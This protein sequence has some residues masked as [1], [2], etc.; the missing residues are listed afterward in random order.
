ME[1][2]SSHRSITIFQSGWHL[3]V[4]IKLFIEECLF[5]NPIHLLIRI[6]TIL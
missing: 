5:Y 4:L 2:E 3:E 6:V 1:A